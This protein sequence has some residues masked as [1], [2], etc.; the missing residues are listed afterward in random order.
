MIL[1]DDGRL[2]GLVCIDVIAGYH[3]ALDVMVV[4]E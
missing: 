2:L 1:K 3:V 4:L